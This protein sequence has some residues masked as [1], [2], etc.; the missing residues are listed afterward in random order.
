VVTGQPPG[1]QSCIVPS[2]EGGSA[3]AVSFENTYNLPRCPQTLQLVCYGAHM[4]TQ[5]VALTDENA[6][7]CRATPMGSAGAA[8]SIKLKLMGARAGMSLTSR[9]TDMYSERYPVARLRTIRVGTV[10]TGRR[11]A[12]GI[13]KL[14]CREPRSRS[15]RMLR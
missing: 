13:V 14:C 2:R 11:A 7:T 15:V 1:S 5:T 12:G 6:A 3:T 4:A 10:A 8:D 9:L